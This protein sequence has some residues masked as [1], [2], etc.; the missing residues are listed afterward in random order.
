MLLPG[1]LSVVHNMN[2]KGWGASLVVGSETVRLSEGSL[3]LVVDTDADRR[4]GVVGVIC[5]LGFGYLWEDLLEPIQ[6][7]G[8]GG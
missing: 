5:D 4:T 3:A 6:S 7:R 2:H 8:V 1:T